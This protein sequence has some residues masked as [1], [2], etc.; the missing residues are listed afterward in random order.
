MLCSENIEIFT[1]IL[2]T[3]TH[4]VVKRQGVQMAPCLICQSLIAPEKRKWDGM[5]KTFD[6]WNIY[7]LCMVGMNSPLTISSGPCHIKLSRIS[8][9]K[10]TS[11]KE[12][13]IDNQ[14]YLRKG[15]GNDQTKRRAWNCSTQRSMPWEDLER[16][17]PEWINN[18]N[19]KNSLVR[20]EHYASR[21]RTLLISRRR[22]SMTIHPAAYLVDGLEF[23]NDIP[24]S[25]DSQDWPPFKQKNVEVDSARTI[26]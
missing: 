5:E 3:A 7:W 24:R 10:P 1:C 22:R 6:F 25:V 17:H 14:N 21:S 9:V 19:S 18:D 11:F 23:L 8:I 15:W 2:H 4:T 12:Q 26:L 13:S 20:I 16:S